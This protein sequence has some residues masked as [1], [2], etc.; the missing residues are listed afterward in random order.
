MSTNA[1][2]DRSAGAA[3]PDEEELEYGEPIPDGETPEPAAPRIAALRGRFG[4]GAPAQPKPENPNG[5]Q[6]VLASAKYLQRDPEP[7]V[8][9]ANE[10]RRAQEQVAGQSLERSV[11]N[12]GVL[13]GITAMT[14]AVAWF[15]A[16][17]VN[18]VVFFYPP[19]LFV[20]GLGAFFKGLT[21]GE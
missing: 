5:G 3:R 6:I 12:S 21:R 13:G 9:R 10:K 15:L 1:K 18:D 2:S 7:E 14:V 20:I 4:G 11:F 17:L 16:G 19:I 8:R